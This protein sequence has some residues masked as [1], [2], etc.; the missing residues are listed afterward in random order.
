MRVRWHS[1]NFRVPPRLRRLLTNT[2]EAT[3]AITLKEEV[4]GSS[5]ADANQVFL[6]NNALDLQ[7]PVRRSKD[8]MV[9]MFEHCVSL[10]RRVLAK[11]KLR[12]IEHHGTLSGTSSHG[13]DSILDGIM[14]VTDLLLFLSCY[15]QGG[16]CDSI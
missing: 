13:D 15:F 16:D 6:A 11:Y 1:G 14:T 10:Q 9:D 5:T 8:Q 7:S 12:M 2:M 4:L 3:Q